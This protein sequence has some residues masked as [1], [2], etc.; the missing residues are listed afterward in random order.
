[1]KSESYRNIVEQS[2]SYNLIRSMVNHNTIHARHTI[3]RQQMDNSAIDIESFVRYTLTDMI[4]N[5]L[6]KRG[7][8]NIIRNDYIYDGISYNSSTGDVAAFEGELVAWNPDDLKGILLVY[9]A[10]L[11]EEF[12]LSTEE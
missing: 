3:D 10:A 2:R 9:G 5:E 12:N 6:K 1:M 11:L 4:V 7:T 8:L